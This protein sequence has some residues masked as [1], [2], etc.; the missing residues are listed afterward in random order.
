MLLENGLERLTLGITHPRERQAA[1]ADVQAHQIHGLLDRDGVH[2]GEERVAQVDVLQLHLTALVGVSIQ[3]AH[4]HIVHQLRQNVGD[5]GDHA[6]RPQGEEGGNLVVV[7]GVDIQLIAAEGHR[8]RQGGDIAVGLLDAAD[9]LV[10][11]E[12]LVSLRL[13]VQPRTA[14]HVVQD[15]RGVDMVRNR[16]VMGD[17][18]VLRRLVV[19]RGHAEQTVHPEVLRL[20]GEVDRI[21]GAVAPGPGDDGDALIDVVDAEFDGGGVL[22]MGQAGVLT[23]RTAHHDGIRAVLNL[24]V[25]DGGKRVKIDV[26]LFVKRRHDRNSGARKKRV[27]HS[28]LPP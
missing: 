6:L 26:A 1:V 28:R 19:I 3:I 27:F 20:L 16:R 11:R 18:A 8:I 21:L 24:I 17:Q 23:G 14:G 22:L 5:H 25:D 9:V 4:D 12:H 10:L 15:D 13:N 2:I 7:A